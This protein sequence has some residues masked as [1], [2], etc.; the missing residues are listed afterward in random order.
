MPH[1]AQQAQ[2]MA[3]AVEQWIERESALSRSLFALRL[4]NGD[5][6]EMMQHGVSRRIADLKHALERVFVV[7]PPTEEAPSQEAIRDTTAF[8][9]AFMI[10]IFGVMDN[11]AWLWRLQA[12]VRGGNGQPLHRSRIGLTPGHRDLRRSLSERSQ[13]CLRGADPWFGYLEEYRHALAHRIP[14]YIPPKTLGEEDAAEFRRLGEQVGAENWDW[15]RWGEVLDAQRSLGVFEPVMMHSYGERARPVWFH[16]QMVCDF[17][18]V[19]D[20]AEHIV[21]D[22]QGLP[23]REV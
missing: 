6:R 14:L 10:N 23:A 9:Q 20:V 13:E 1:T 22:L 2:Q 16:G 21:Q 19:I 12:D 15:A 17:A 4:H 18:T 5:A 7:I 11:L 3:E 8:L